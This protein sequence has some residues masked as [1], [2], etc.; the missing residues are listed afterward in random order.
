VQTNGLAYSFLFLYSFSVNPQK[1]I[2]PKKKE[3]NTAAISHFIK[4]RIAC[5]IES[6]LLH[7]SSVPLMKIIAKKAN[8]VKLQNVIVTISSPK[9][10]NTTTLTTM[11]LKKPKFH[12]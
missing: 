11:T 10:S 8:F 3:R 4:I 2:F 6:D 12:K 1:T 5:F 7:Q 9:H